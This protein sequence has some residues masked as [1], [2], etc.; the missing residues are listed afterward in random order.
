MSA[1][2]AVHGLV[3]IQS[4]IREA[5]VPGSA[6]YSRQ[7]VT[8]A[9]QTSI[10]LRAHLAHMSDP[11]AL[12]FGAE[13]AATGAPCHVAIASSGIRVRVDDPPPDASDRLVSFT[14]LSVSVGGVNHDQL[15]LTWNER[16]Q[17]DAL[18]QRPHS[19]RDSR[20]RRRIQGTRRGGEDVRGAGNHRTLG[21]LLGVVLSCLSSGSA[22]LWWELQSDAFRPMGTEEGEANRIFYTTHC[23]QQG[24]P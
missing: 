2:S 20:R 8:D 1:D 14:R 3:Y 16:G 12:C 23:R 13:F 17:A 7:R 21:G 9:A 18:R 10:C 15:V 6:V 11:N 24:R 19:Q 5:S 4:R 22:H